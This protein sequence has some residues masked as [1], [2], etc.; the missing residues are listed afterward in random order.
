MSCCALHC[1]GQT[2]SLNKVKPLNVAKTQRGTANRKA[3]HLQPGLSSSA[4]WGPQESL[5]LPL[6]FLLSKLLTA[7]GT[8]MSRT[9][10]LLQI[11]GALGEFPNLIFPIPQASTLRCSFSLSVFAENFSGIYCSLLPLGCWSADSQRVVF[12]SAQRSR[13]VKAPHCVGR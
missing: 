4:A 5:L 1:G 9:V 12:D 3:S 10:I 11:S 8:L 7:K 2:R 6:H 13:L